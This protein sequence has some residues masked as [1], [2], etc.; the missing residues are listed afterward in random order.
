MPTLINPLRELQESWFMGQAEH[1]EGHPSET[2]PQ[3]NPARGRN[4]SDVPSEIRKTGHLR[5]FT[6]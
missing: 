5:G 1:A 6:G 4:I 3:L 2:L